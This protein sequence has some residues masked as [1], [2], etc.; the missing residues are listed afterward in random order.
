MKNSFKIYEMNRLIHSDDS[1][2]FNYW[3]YEENI[4][5]PNNTVIQIVLRPAMD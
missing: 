3:K 5:N 2:G 4:S 1:R